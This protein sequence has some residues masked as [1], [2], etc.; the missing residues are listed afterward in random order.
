[1]KK[2]KIA[3]VIKY[4]SNDYHVMDLKSLACIYDSSDCAF[5]AVDADVLESLK[6]E[7]AEKECPTNYAMHKLIMTQQAVWLNRPK[8]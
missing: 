1:M 7:F 8:G 6:K 5:F 4:K 2:E 3:I